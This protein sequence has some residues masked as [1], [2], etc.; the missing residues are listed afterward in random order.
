[1]KLSCGILFYSNK[2]RVLLGHATGMFHWDI[3]KGIQEEG[4]SYKDTAIRETIEECGIKIDGS[5]LVELGLFKYM[6]GK[7]LVIFSCFIDDTFDI[8]NLECTTFVELENRKP[9]PEMDNYSFFTENESFDHMSKS[10][11][12][13]FTKEDIFAQLKAIY[14]V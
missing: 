12:K 4:E 11:C 2:G 6:P 13:L 3:F 10:L 1:M 7:N 5:Q 8:S 9:F 14:D